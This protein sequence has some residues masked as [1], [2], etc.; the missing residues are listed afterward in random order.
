MSRKINCYLDRFEGDK[1]VLII[2]G[3]EAY[4]PRMLLP[5]EVSEGDYLKIDMSIDAAKRKSV[6]S[7]IAE[8]Q[9]RLKSGDG[10]PQ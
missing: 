9:E 10:E 4:I 8:L 2:D 3:I 5:N 7:E 6:S 1:A